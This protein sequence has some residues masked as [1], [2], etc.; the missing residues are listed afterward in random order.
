MRYDTELAEMRRCRSH[1]RSLLPQLAVLFDPVCP[2][3]ARDARL[4]AATLGLIQEEAQGVS[5]HRAEPMTDGFPG[6]SRV[7]NREFWG[8]VHRA[9]IREGPESFPAPDHREGELGAQ[10]ASQH[11]PES[12]PEPPHG[13]DRQLGQHLLHVDA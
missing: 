9:W 10:E 13:P 7:E 3:D 2:S 8:P 6:L 12:N 1:H 4:R 5:S 11:R